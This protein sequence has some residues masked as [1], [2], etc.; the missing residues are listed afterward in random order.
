MFYFNYGLA[1]FEEGKLTPLAVGSKKITE[2][3]F[4]VICKVLDGIK[5]QDATKKPNER[6]VSKRKPKPVAKQG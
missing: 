4:N 5:N 3:D 6:K 1:K 2:V